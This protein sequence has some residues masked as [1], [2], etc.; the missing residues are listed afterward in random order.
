VSGLLL[1]DAMSPES[2]LPTPQGK[3][4]DGIDVSS[5][6]SALV[7]LS[8]ATQPPPV[9]NSNSV[10]GASV[11]G[12]GRLLPR[13]TA[14]YAHQ[15]LRRTT[16]D[17]DVHL[18]GEPLRFGEMREIGVSGETRVSRNTRLAQGFTSPELACDD[19]LVSLSTKDHAR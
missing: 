4:D 13:P 10:S 18:L 16:T 19:P 9:R 14:N 5:P 6:S 11:C 12:C 1:R 7:P 15:R 8:A 3:D 2:L 17:R